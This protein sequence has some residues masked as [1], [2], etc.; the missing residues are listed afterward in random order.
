MNAYRKRKNEVMDVEDQL[1][2]YVSIN[3]Q[4]QLQPQTN[5]CQ[6]CE[7]SL[8]WIALCVFAC[9]GAAGVVLIIN[10]VKHS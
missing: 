6:R 9:I 8:P 4:Q 1:D 7:N 3:E 5:C 2:V 10:I